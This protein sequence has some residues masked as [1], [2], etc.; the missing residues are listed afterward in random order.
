MAGAALGEA[1]EAPKENVSGCWGQLPPVG[2]CLASQPVWPKAEANS[3]SPVWPAESAIGSEELLER[4]AGRDGVGIRA[5]AVGRAQQGEGG[6]AQWQEAARRR[7]G[8]LT[9]MAELGALLVPQ[10]QVLIFHFQMAENP[11]GEPLAVPCS[12]GT[13]AFE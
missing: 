11:D 1:A 2:I 13:K 4:A 8:T 12:A 3:K 9:G 10:T 5:A 6:E 7:R